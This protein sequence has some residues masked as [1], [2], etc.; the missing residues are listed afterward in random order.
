MQN[1]TNNTTD[2]ETPIPPK[3]QRRWYQSQGLALSMS[4]ISLFNLMVSINV[5][6]W[7]MVSNPSIL[8]LKS[9]G[10]SYLQQF[11]IPTQAHTIESTCS[12]EAEFRPH[13]IGDGGL[14]V[15]QDRRITI[16]DNLIVAVET[17]QL[18][19]WAPEHQGMWIWLGFSLILVFCML[20]WMVT[21]F[22]R[23]QTNEPP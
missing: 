8:I 16:A 23:G 5:L 21:T 7:Q 14:I 18:S 12:L 19:L 15:Y 1:T 22:K 3:K 11:G 2:S 17:I 4:L 9:Q 13:I 6:P 20:T 10:C